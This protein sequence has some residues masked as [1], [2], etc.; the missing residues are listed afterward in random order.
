[1]VK[2]KEFTENQKNRLAEPGYYIEYCGLPNPEPT[3]FS[4]IYIGKNIC[5][6]IHFGWGTEWHTLTWTCAPTKKK[7]ESDKDIKNNKKDIFERYIYFPT[8]EELLKFKNI[9]LKPGALIP[10]EEK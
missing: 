10:A 1:M 8:H 5:R 3:E 9:H 2:K 7:I 4:V 6:Y